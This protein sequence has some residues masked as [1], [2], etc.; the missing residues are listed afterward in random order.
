MASTADAYNRAV[1]TSSGISFRR[2]RGDANLLAGTVGDLIAARPRRAVSPD[3]GDV[4]EPD[5]ADQSRQLGD[6][7]R[8]GGVADVREQAAQRHA[9]DR[10]VRVPAHHVPHEH[11]AHRHVLLDGVTARRPRDRPGARRQAD[12]RPHRLR[13]SHVRQPLHQLLPVLR[14]RAEVPPAAVR[15]LAPLA[16]AHARDALRHTGR[17]P[18]DDP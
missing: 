11:D 16:A 17:E 3:C 6:E 8:R 9:A 1:K 7:R 18:V 12:P 14:H 10:L 4:D 2:R 5:A 15:A 13:A